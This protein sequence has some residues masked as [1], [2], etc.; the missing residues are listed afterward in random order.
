[1]LHFDYLNPGSRL[2]L[3]EVAARLN[4]Q[5]PEFEVLAT[6]L[7]GMGV[8]LQLR[9]VSNL[10]SYGL[11]CIRPELL[12]DDDTWNRFHDELEVWISASGCDA[13]VEA[14][15]IVKINDVPSVLAKW[16]A[17]GDLTHVLSKLNPVQKFETVVR[18]LRA[19]QWAQ[20]KLG[21]VHR[22]VKPTNILYDNTSLAYLSDW[23]L[24]RPLRNVL[25]SASDGSDLT[26][27]DRPDRT[28]RNGFIGTVTHAAPEQI[29][30][31]AT[32]DHRADIYALGC[33]MFELE[34]G[35]PPFNGSTFQEIAYKHLHVAPAKL[36]GMFR[37]TTLGLERVIDRCLAK[38]PN[39]RYG[40]YRELEDDLLTVASKRNFP[41]D[42]CIVSERYTR[43][44][45]GKGHEAQKKAIENA[46]IKGK[47]VANS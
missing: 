15:T 27:I 21:V 3:P 30:N 23:G 4:I 31:A 20:T 37:Q 2:E 11:K 39:A 40:T 19:L 29:L 34:T 36:G 18:V 47:N 10:E 16:M 13:V 1:M 9:S 45:L 17:G 24:S 38:D 22:D 25:D 41:L 8:C 12:G 14:I 6:H 35:A 33:I 28:Q 7:G 5:S 26:A 43:Y 32:V 44:Q 42:R 46:E